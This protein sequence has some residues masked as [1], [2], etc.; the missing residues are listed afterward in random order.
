MKRK[1]DPDHFECMGV[2]HSNIFEALLSTCQ[3]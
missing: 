2:N 1:Y 3:A